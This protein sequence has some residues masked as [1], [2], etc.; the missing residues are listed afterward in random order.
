MTGWKREAKEKEIMAPSK[1]GTSKKGRR[2]RAPDE[3]NPERAS[4]K[5]ASQEGMVSEQVACQ[6]GT[7]R[8]EV[9]GVNS[10]TRKRARKSS[11]IV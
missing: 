3:L 10:R 2:R 9:I 7:A 4:E 1:C 11:V 5:V 6:E 8:L